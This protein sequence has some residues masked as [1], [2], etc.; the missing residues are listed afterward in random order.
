MIEDYSKERFGDNRLSWIAGM[1]LL[2]IMVIGL[3]MNEVK[4]TGVLPDGSPV[5]VSAFSEEA[6]HFKLNKKLSKSGY[7]HFVRV[8]YR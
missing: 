6:A 4:I 7:D 5:S 8:I 2:L 3:A 1:L